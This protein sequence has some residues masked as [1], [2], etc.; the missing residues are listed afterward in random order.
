MGKL[1]VG[2]AKVVITPKE[3][4]FPFPQSPL[5]GDAVYTHVRKDAF[6]RA[7]SI[8]DGKERLMLIVQ[9]TSGISNS[10]IIKSRISQALG[11][12]E[13]CIVLCAMHNHSMAKPVELDSTAVW[14]VKH[15]PVQYR[16]SEYLIEQTVHAAIEAFS[17]ERPAR[18]GYGEGKSYINVNRDEQ[19]PDGRYIFG[20]NFERPSDKTL[21]VMK[22]E[23]MDGKLIAAVMNYA[24]HSTM[25]FRVKDSDGNLCTS[26]DLGGEI[27][28]FVESAYKD[29]G[30]VAV[31]TAGA[32]GNQTSILSFFH[33]YY[34]DGTYEPDE[35]YNKFLDPFMWKL[36]E[37]LGQ[38]Q[39]MDTIKILRAIKDMK[40]SASIRIADR[41]IELPGTKV[42]GFGVPEL[43][44]DRLI[45]DSRIYN[46]D[47]DP[48]PMALK[49]ITLGNLAIY[50]VNCELMAE[51][52]LRL[53]MESAYKN[54][55]LLSYYENSS[56]GRYFVDPWGYQAHTPAYY[57]N[58]V[59]DACTEEVLC[60]QLREMF[61]ELEE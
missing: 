50:C 41:N 1:R 10:P 29:D 34:P 59:K 24:V 42:E 19:L 14:G 3:D 5:N 61:H 12:S 13:S 22:F 43:R 49:L 45:D 27:A 53:K 37:H 52:G 48:V 54:T 18:F 26:G 6:V 23:D 35:M 39:G 28:S 9:E 36:C 40:E 56:G 57:R 20:R 8:Y 17:N 16:F 30:A 60:T 2:A 15:L 7:V 46:T 51:T 25:C 11:I 38:L 21:S 47:A 58:K 4:M 31:W 55:V 33:T 44:D 32:A